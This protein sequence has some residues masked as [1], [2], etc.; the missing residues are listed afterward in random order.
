[1]KYASIVVL[2]IVA[3]ATALESSERESNMITLKKNNLIIRKKKKI[4]FL[5][6]QAAILKDFARLCHELTLV[7]TLTLQDIINVIE[8]YHLWLTT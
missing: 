2:R 7:S 8:K 3:T 1:M 6:W 5:D 4:T